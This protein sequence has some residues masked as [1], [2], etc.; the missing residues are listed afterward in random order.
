MAQMN[1]RRNIR[2]D[3]MFAANSN[4]SILRECGWRLCFLRLHK[5]HRSRLQRLLSSMNYQEGSFCKKLRILWASRRSMQR[6]PG[7]H[8]FSAIHGKFPT[9]IDRSRMEQTQKKSCPTLPA[10]SR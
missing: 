1:N 6:F 7:I 8:T 10:V 2:E 3:E 5:M 9:H 4:V